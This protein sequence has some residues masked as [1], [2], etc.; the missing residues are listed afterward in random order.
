[1]NTHSTRSSYDIAI[2]TIFTSV[3]PDIKKYLFYV[4]ILTQCKVIFDETLPAIA[5][6]SFANFKYNLYINPIMFSKLTIP[7]RIGVLKHE[8]LHIIDLH[9]TLRRKDYDNHNWNLATDCAIN[10]LIN[11]DHLPENCVTIENLFTDSNIKIASKMNAEYYYNLIKENEEKLNP[12]FAKGTGSTFDELME[13]DDQQSETSIKEITKEIIKSAIESTKNCGE[14]PSEVKI[15]LELKYKNE[16]NWRK[17]LQKIVGKLKSDKKKTIMK[18]NRRNP[19]RKDLY[20]NKRDVKN[21]I[22]VI[23]DESGSVS[24][25][26]EAKALSEIISLC[27]LF[28]IEVDLIRVDTTASDIIKLNKNSIKYKRIKSGGTYISSAIEKIKKDYDVIIILT[29]GEL[30]QKDINKFKDLD[31]QIIW[32]IINSKEIDGNFE[33]KYMRKIQIKHFKG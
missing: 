17:E 15:I 24:D 30:Y 19:Q 28:K 7:H 4:H 22:L 13:S 11:K 3:D 10:Q 14:I 32:L 26:A 25:S 1:M 21:E 31:T 2:Q 12:D 16:I 6:V 29:D 33:S 23:T 27:Q 20:G 18:P 9:L 5:G 8:M